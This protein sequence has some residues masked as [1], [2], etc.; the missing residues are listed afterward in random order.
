MLNRLEPKTVIVHGFMPNDIFYEFLDKVEFV[1]YPSE[2]EVS[3]R[4]KGD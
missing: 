3:R 4:K 2:F 1:R